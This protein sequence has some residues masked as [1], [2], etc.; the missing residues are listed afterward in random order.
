MISRRA[1]L[2]SLATLTMLAAFPVKAAEPAAFTEPAFQAALGSGKAVLID[3]D[4]SWCPTCA[5][6]RPILGKLL[7]ESFQQMVEFRVDF[8]SQKDVVRKFGA[9]SQSTLIL[10]NKG[11]EVGR[12]VGD[13]DPASI[14][15]LLR[16]AS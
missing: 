6:Q 16:K 3:I 15:A 2:F 5:A 13:T 4:A 12:S 1:A 8:D 11:A 7:S 14:E 9:R 10:F